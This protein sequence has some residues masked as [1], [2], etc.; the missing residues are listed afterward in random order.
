M[1]LFDVY[2]LMDVEPAEA[3]GLWI[4]GADGSRY[5][6]FYGGHA[7][8]SIGHSH[9]HYVERI[10]TQLSRIGFY[11]NA[12][13]NPLQVELADLLGEVSGYP[14]YNLFLCNSGAEANENAL[15]V[16]SFVTGRDR[17]VAMRGAFH[18]RTSAAVAATDNPSIQAPVNSGHKVSFVPLGDLEALEKEVAAGD[19]AAV[20]IEGIQGVGGIRVASDE[21]LLGARA[22]CDK[23][24]AMLILDEVQSGY[25]RSGKFFAHQYSGVKP[26]IIS[27]AKGMGNGFPVAGILIAPTIEARKGMLGTTFGGSHLA[28]SAALAVLEVIRD[29]ELVKSAAEKGEYLISAIRQMEGISEVR[30]RGLMIGVE[31]PVAQGVFRKQLLA[32]YGIMT[33]YSG[34]NTLRLLPP[35]CV[36]TEECDM[37]LSALKNTLSKF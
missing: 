14:D 18:G 33:G 10:S 20:M 7:V 9:P 31:L 1:G 5:L 37:L 15:K 28:C 11:S 4:T 6:D 19:V 23:Y 21:F 34:T 8:I 12:V 27:M 30:G 29:E 16:A 35:L 3:R 24:G 13:Q 36:T 32:D 2:T 26:D 17:V 22:V 25:G